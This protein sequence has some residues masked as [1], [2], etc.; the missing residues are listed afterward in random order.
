MPENLIT[1]TF[2]SCF[3]HKIGPDTLPEKLITLTFGGKFNQCI[4]SEM[5][6][7]NLK[8]INFNWMFLDLFDLSGYHIEM[9]N[10]IPNYY[11]VVLLLKKNIFGIND[12]GH[13]WPIHLL[14]V[15]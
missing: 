1:L 2:G 3:N 5:L 9:V 10:N 6:P 14:V 12:D 7:S 8:N 11:H 4:D 15:G 13:K